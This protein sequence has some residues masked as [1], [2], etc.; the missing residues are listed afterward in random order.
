MR[1]KILAVV[2]A[3]AALVSV[4]F[5]SAASAQGF[6]SGDTATVASDEV[7]NSTLWISGRTIDVAGEVNGDVFCAGQSVTISGTVRGDLLCAAQTI[8]VSGVVTGDVRSLAQTA[9]V[10]GTIIHNL[11]MAV[12]TVSQGS[13]STIRGDAS[14]A[15]DNV[16]LNGS[17]GRDA[18]IASTTINLN[19]G[20]GR[21]VKAAATDLRLGSK[22]NVKGDLNYTSQKNA[23]LASGAQVGG[24][25]NKTTPE[26]QPDKKNAT[27]LFGLGLGL[28]LY[29][30]LAA[31]ATT[32]VLVLFFPQAIHAISDQ[33][34]QSLWKSL[35]VGLVAY[36]AVPALVLVLFLTIIGIPLALL[37]ILAWLLIQ[38]FAGVVSAYYLGRQI[39]RQQRNPVLVMLLGTVVLIA[40]YFVPIVG[41][42]AFI[43]AML[44]GTGMILLALNRRRPSPKYRLAE[45]PID[46]PIS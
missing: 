10:S 24:E 42:I 36:L 28:V 34:F 31:L 41:M 16:S 39:L 22:A 46:Q 21:N 4:G 44:L 8:V 45:K 1:H 19:G 30:L 38:M 13:K 25:T 7:V 17:V 3:C 29:L 32:M 12:Q 37:I 40:L 2:A 11:S 26:E 18:A 43:L 5:W 15:A 20:V 27:S 23:Q 9:T 35:L 14:L 33:G 6:R